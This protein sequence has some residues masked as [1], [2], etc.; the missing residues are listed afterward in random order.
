L[1]KS[2]LDNPETLASLGKQET[3]DEDKQNTQKTQKTKT[4][5][6]TD[7]TKTPWVI[8]GV[9]VHNF[10]ITI[11]EHLFGSIIYLFYIH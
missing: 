10:N 2:R 11:S 3:Q 5:G 7:P 6:N 8:P 1:G 9:D 4:M